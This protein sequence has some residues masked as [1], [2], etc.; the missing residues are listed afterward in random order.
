MN[1][2]ELY[3]LGLKEYNKHINEVSKHDYIVVVNYRQPSHERRFYVFDLKTGALLRRHHVAHGVNS[4][5]PTNRDYSVKFGNEIG[6]KMSSLGSIVTAETYTGR[7][8]LSLKLDGLEPGINDNMRRRYIVIH[9][10][11]YVSDNFIRKNGRL[12]QSDGCLVLDKAVYKK[13]I[14]MIKGGTFIYSVY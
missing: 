2:R 1:E 3:E 14:E 10:A 9:T 8:G 13:V 7:H 4:S 5:Y 11:P 12:G 6:S